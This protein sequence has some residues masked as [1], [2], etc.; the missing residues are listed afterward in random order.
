MVVQPAETEVEESAEVAAEEAGK[1]SAATSH[2]ESKPQE[3][4]TI[5]DSLPAGVIP[6]LQ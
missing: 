5:P 1:K 3:N 2:Q 6:P 4:Q